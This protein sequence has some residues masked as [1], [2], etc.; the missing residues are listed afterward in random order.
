MYWKYF[1][2]YLKFLIRHKK[3]MVVEC[4]RMNILWRG[5]VHDISK[6]LPTEFICY[7]LNFY[8]RPLV[9]LEFNDTHELVKDRE[10][11]NTNIDMKYRETNLYHMHRNRHHW[12][13][14]VKP[15]PDGYTLIE[16]P[17]VYTKE[18]V[19][20]WIACGVALG[21]GREGAL[22]WYKDNKND[23]MLHSITRGRVE[24]LLDLHKESLRKEYYIKKRRRFL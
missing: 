24:E 9:P 18:M 22:I 12:E 13:H 8:G 23:I 11:L 1:K 10:R 2:K 16:M 5:I 15:R 4:F 19:C 6:L 14:W 20:D 21:Q 7:A 17:V 3:S